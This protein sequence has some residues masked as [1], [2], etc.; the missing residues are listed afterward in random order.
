MASFG[1][2]DPKWSQYGPTWPNITKLRQIHF[3]A[4]FWVIVG[5]MAQFG[6]IYHISHI[7]HIGHNIHLK[8]YS[9]ETRQV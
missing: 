7:S 4:P 9:D 8:Q 3:A 1:K 6:H 5:Q 2:M